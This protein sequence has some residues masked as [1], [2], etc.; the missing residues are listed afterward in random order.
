[1]ENHIF[2]LFVHDYYRQK[3]NY[4]RKSLF[5]VYHWTILSKEFIV[6]GESVRHIFFITHNFMYFFLE[7]RIL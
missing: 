6:A 1:M 2:L 4:A 5:S 3:I 7:S